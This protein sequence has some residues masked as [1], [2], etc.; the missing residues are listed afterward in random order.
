MIHTYKNLSGH[1]I[2]YI[3]ESTTQPL[4]IVYTRD[5]VDTPANTSTCFSFWVYN[6]TGGV[7]FELE[8]AQGDD[9]QARLPVAFM[10]MNFNDPQWR[11]T[12]IV[13]PYTYR[14][15]PFMLFTNITGALDM[16][17]IQVLSCGSPG[18]VPPVITI[19]NCDFDQNLCPDLI[20]LSNYSYHWSTIQAE[21]AQNYS[22][23]APQVDYSVGDKTG[24]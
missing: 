1:Y 13:L 4:T 11:G 23:T 21:E 9:L 14:S 8:L 3:N 20:S 24:T 5:W 15:I 10:G 18:P 6:G 22:S 19:L 2:T 7:Y 16:D 17:D 12:S